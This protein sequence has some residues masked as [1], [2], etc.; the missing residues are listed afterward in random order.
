MAG[1]A[2]SRSASCTYVV[3]E[4]YLVYARVANRV[5]LYIPRFGANQTT[6]LVAD[7]STEDSYFVDSQHAALQRTTVF[8]QQRTKLLNVGPFSFKECV[9]HGRRYCLARTLYQAEILGDALQY[10]WYTVTAKQLIIQC[11]CCCHAVL[12]VH[13]RDIS[14]NVVSSI[15]FVVILVLVLTIMFDIFQC[16][17]WRA[18][19][20]ITHKTL[21]RGI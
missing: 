3:E 2:F 15:I 13:L 18:S 17:A 11:S 14:S 8:G 19:A 12:R 21:P 7:E 9:G 5:L 10:T 4:R 16:A 1:A 6:S 20:V